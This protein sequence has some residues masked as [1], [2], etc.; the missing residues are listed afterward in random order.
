MNINNK[1]IKNIVT[2]VARLLLNF[3]L[4][5]CGTPKKASRDTL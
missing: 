2:R 5:F 1:S 3:L 4:N